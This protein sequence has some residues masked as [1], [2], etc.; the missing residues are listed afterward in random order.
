MRKEIPLVIT[1]LA[2]TAVILGY[3]LDVPIFEVTISRMVLNWAVLIAAFALAL[4]AGNLTIVHSRAIQ[5]RSPNWYLSVLLIVSLYGYLVLGVVRGMTSLEYQWLFHGV[6]VPGNATV[7]SLNGF[8]I[9]SAAYRTWR[10]RNWRAALLVITALLVTL[11][12]VGIGQAMW[13]E[14][15]PISS[16]IMSFP[17]AAGMRGIIIGAA[18]GTISLGSRVI[19]G[20]ERSHFGAE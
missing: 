2:G 18:L 14:L 5:R 11:G 12:R 17:N 8:F 7:F 1:F 16:W 4:G 3:F 20:I 19:L 6:L 15:G 10:L 9:I 13:P